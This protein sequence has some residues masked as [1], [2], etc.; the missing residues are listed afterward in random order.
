M[1]QSQLKNIWMFHEA[2]PDQI[3][4]ALIV[5]S[6][7]AQMS[8]FLLNVFLKGFFLS[9]SYKLRLQCLKLSHMLYNGTNELLNALAEEAV[10]AQSQAK[11]SALHP[12]K[13]IYPEYMMYSLETSWTTK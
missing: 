1:R 2:Y 4:A 8:E 9:Y 5:A 6:T 11:Y 12:V 7:H 10:D 3:R 13:N